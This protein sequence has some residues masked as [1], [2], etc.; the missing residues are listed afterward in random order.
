M[1]ANLSPR[2]QLPSK[3]V[4]K[5]AFWFGARAW[6]LITH[7]CVRICGYVLAKAQRCCER[8]YISQL[9]KP[10]ALNA[11][12]S[13]LVFGLSR[14]SPNIVEDHWSHIRRT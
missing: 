5:T 8:L 14:C 6:A 1:D 13:T 7:S 10:G 12:L 4:H 11:Y 2:D 3:T 9:A